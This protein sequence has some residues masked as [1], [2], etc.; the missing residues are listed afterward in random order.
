[1]KSFRNNKTDVIPGGRNAQ[2]EDA[3][4]GYVGYSGL[5][6]RVS[7]ERSEEVIGDGQLEDVVVKHIRTETGGG[8]VSYVQM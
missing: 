2:D 4:G 6:D 3:D 7:R 8:G 5:Q 1:M